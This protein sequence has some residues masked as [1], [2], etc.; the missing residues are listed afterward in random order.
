MSELPPQLIES[1][2]PLRSRAATQAAWVERF[3]RFA[4]SGLSLAQFCGQEG[5]SLPSFYPWKRRLAGALPT[6]T[7]AEATASRP[8]L[9]PVRLPL[10]DAAVEFVHPGGVIL[11]L[12]SGC[13]PAFVRP[14]VKTSG[15]ASC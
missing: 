12:R 6:D 1:R 5:V 15:G 2:R 3:A 7:P 13:D 11:R 14:L 10:V 4:H 9:L 8:R